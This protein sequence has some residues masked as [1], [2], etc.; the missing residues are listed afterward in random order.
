MDFSQLKRMGLKVYLHILKD[1]SK[2]NS[3]TDVPGHLGFYLILFSIWL[4][5]SQL[6]QVEIQE[7]FSQVY[8]LSRATPYICSYLTGHT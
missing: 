2:K 5:L 4:I 8:L 7:E 1:I 6:I 3:L